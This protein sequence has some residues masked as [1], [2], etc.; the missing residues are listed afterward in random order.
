[1]RPFAASL[2]IAVGLLFLFFGGRSLYRGVA[3][4]YWP[5][6]EGRVLSSQVKSERGKRGGLV[7]SAEVNY[8]YA[9]NAESFTCQRIRFGNIHTGNPVLPTQL[10][11]KYPAGKSVTVHY[12]GSDPFLA[13]LEP[14]IQSAS[15]IVVGIGMLFAG[16]GVAAILIPKRCIRHSR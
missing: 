3:S 11:E 15:L 9:V 10:V 14:G 4:S 7:Y 5:T 2:F 8:A 12:C 6:V 1:M 16:V 13:L